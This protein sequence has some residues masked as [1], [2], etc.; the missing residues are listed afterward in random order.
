MIQLPEAPRQKGMGKKTGASQTRLSR[1]QLETLRSLEQLNAISLDHAVPRQVVYEVLRDKAKQADEKF[2]DKHL[3]GFYLSALCG[4]GFIT[5]MN[6]ECKVKNFETQ[7]I[8]WVKKPVWFL[9]EKYLSGELQVAPDG[10]IL[11]PQTVE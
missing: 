6:K 1:K 7:E 2:P 10:L 3:V 11:K 8:R 9:S 5:M 4:A